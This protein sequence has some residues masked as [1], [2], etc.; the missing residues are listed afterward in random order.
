M[1]KV[2]INK[3]DLKDNLQEIR[4]YINPIDNENDVVKIIAVVK[5]NGMGLG[6]VEYSRFLI[7]NG[8]DILAV[9]T[10]DEAIKLR[11]A[12]IDKD[13][14]MLSP[15]ISEEEL[16][17]LIDNEI[18]LTL[19]SKHQIEL[20]EQKAI[21]KKIKAHIKIDTG[22]GRYGFL[23]SNKTEIIEA[24]K[25]CKNIEITGMY[26]HFSKPIDKNWTQIQFTRFLEVIEI[27]RKNGLDPGLL[28][29][30]NSTAFMLYKNMH[31]NAVRLGSIIQGRTLVNKKAFKKIGTFKSNIAQIKNVPKGYNISYGRNYKTKKMTKIAIVPVGYI[32]GLNYKK[33]RDSFKL[34]ENIISVLMEIKKIF[35]DN[36]LK[37][38]I[39][40]NEFKIIGRLGMYHA[41]IDITGFDIK[42]GDE[43]ILDIHPLNANSDIR[44]EYI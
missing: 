25:L 19:D 16:N 9:A 6:L 44:R 21:D 20:C 12:K 30:C 29:C 27:V 35:K 39:N 31:L 10:T 17:L 42:P 32:D 34:S 7:E 22:F 33:A 41:I 23:Y 28:H 26:T 14:L 11:N 1:K 5:S 3:N 37:V 18:I 8:I 38:K 36:S 13:I 24:M 43:V 15:V 2:V 40:E 4:K